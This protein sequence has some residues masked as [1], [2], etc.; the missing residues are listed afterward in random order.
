VLADVNLLDGA[1]YAGDPIPVYRRLRDESP[2][3]WDPVNRLWGISRHHDVV[4]VEKHAHRY[5]SSLGSRPRIPGDVSMINNDDPLHQSRRRLVARRFTPRSVKEH[6]DHVRRVVT[7]LIDRVIDDGGCDVITAFAAPLPAQVICE[8]LGFPP[9]LAAKCREWSEITMLEGGQ[10]NPDG[11]ERVTGETTINAVLEFATAALEV[12]DARRGDP[13]DDLIS[14]W[15][16]A[17]VEQPD[18]TMRPLADDEIV[19]EALLLLDGGAE[20]TR[21]VIGTMCLELI[22][23]PDQHAALAADPGILATTGVEEFIRWVTPILNM[24]RTA[25]E[26]HELHGQI[27]HAGD[28]MLLMYSAAN[29]DERVFDDPDTLDV[30]RAHNHHVAFG[31]GTHFCLGASLARLEIRVMF[32]ELV[33]RLPEMRLA[34]GADPKKV[35]SAFA[36]A[37]DAIPVEF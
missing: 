27:V 28:E 10:Y 5:T 9:E 25:T 6:E 32:E 2:A 19:H 35:P 16:H 4:E 12:L 23:H 13:K 21:T 18:G 31:F 36:C 8:M 14:V 34:A 7:D 33:Q 24:R 20:T 22:R 17:E 29:R 37:Y 3:Y 11:S 26:D 1:L 30:T 15:A